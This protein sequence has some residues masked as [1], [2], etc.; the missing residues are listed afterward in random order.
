[1]GP[2]ASLC[3]KDEYDEVIRQVIL[4]L[5]GR[6]QEVTRDLRLH[7]REASE[8]LEYERAARLRD[9]IRAIE[10]TSER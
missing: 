2:C 5:E 3:S 10:R 9:Q 6:T 7:M 8:G 1:I 4:F